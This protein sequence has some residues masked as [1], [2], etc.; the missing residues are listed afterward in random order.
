MARREHRL[1]PEEQKRARQVLAALAVAAA[2][3][4]V[5]LVLAWAPWHRHDGEGEHE[6]LVAPH[7]GTL[8]SLG[9]SEPHDHAE[10]VLELGGGLTVYTLQPDARASRQVQRQVLTARVRAARND[11]HA[12]AMLVP[13]PLPDDPPGTTSRFRGRLPEALWGRDV[14]VT[15][16]ELAVADG[17]FKVEFDEVKSPGD[18]AR[19]QAEQTRLFSNPG[20]KY[21]QGD[22]EA[23]GSAT[24]A[25]KFADHE[26]EHDLAPGKEGW[27]CPVAAARSEP[28]VAWSVAGRKYRFC[29]SVCI[30]EFVRLAK[31]Q[32]GLVKSPEAYWKR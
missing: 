17:R 13:M 6:H 32:P 4:V 30:D 10:A 21:T 14:S 2:L 24:A 23:N 12:R 19:H 15:V 18:L 20:G 3:V 29:C 31:E 5:V 27:L 25:G 1:T 22:I 7:G 8:A 16:A 9:L 11:R 26:V 28:G